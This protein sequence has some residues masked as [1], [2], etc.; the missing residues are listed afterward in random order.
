MNIFKKWGLPKW[1]KVDNGRPLG[2]P[3]KE[4]IPVLA[5]WLIGLGIKVIWNRPYMPQDNAKVER[6]QNTLSIWTEYEKCQNGL[7]LQERLLEQAHFYNYHFPIRRL[8]KQKRIEAFPNLADTGKSFRKADFR[9]QPILDFLSQGNWERSVN[10]NGQIVIYGQRFSVGKKYHHQRVSIK[11]CPKS[12]KWKVYE[13]KGQ[14]IK[15]ITS[16]FSKKNIW[17]LDLSNCQ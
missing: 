1:I 13:A 16:P 3:Q 6:C 5:L 2:D 9:V 15:S 17:K 11:L 4:L 7:E 12:N 8:N 10:T 14:L